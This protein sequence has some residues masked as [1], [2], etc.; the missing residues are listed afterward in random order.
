MESD[1]ALSSNIEDVY[2]LQPS[3][4]D[5]STTGPYPREIFEDVPKKVYAGMFVTAL[6]VIANLFKQ[7]QC[8]LR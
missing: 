1:L 5:P 3:L 2:T 8:L 6:F 4:T 7:P